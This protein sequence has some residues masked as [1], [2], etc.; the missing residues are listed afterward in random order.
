M[1]Q[2]ICFT[3]LQKKRNEEGQK[4]PVDIISSG[5]NLAHPNRKLQCRKRQQ[6]RAVMLR[7]SFVTG[8]ENEQNKRKK[9]LTAADVGTIHCAFF[10]KAQFRALR[11]ESELH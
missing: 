7:K 6:H 4:S 11:S 8:G 5:K 10:S 9:S 1:Q 3:A 2:Q